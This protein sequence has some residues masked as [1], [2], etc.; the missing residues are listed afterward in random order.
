MIFKALV[1]ET[2]KDTDSWEMVEKQGESSVCSTSQ[3][4]EL[5]GHQTEKRK[6]Q[7]LI[8]V[9]RAESRSPQKRRELYKETTLN[10]LQ[11]VYF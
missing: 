1:I 5:L 4:S 9:H 6:P 2:K 8:W 3:Q 11:R 10:I 7:S